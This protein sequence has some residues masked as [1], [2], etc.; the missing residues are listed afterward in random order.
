MRQVPVVY[1]ED[2]QYRSIAMAQHKQYSTIF[3]EL[4]KRA[5]Q[6]IKES[7]EFEIEEDSAPRIEAKRME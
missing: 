1:P 5:D 7:I 2:R 3:S 4:R 6:R